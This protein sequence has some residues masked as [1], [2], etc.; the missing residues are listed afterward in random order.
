MCAGPR[1][2]LQGRQVGSISD[3]GAFSFCQDKILTGGEGGMLVTNDTDAWAKAW[4]YKDHGK[5]YDAIYRQPTPGPG[6][7]NWVH[8]S[9]GTN[10]RITE[11]QAAIGRVQLRKLGDWLKA[12]RRNAA[13]LT[14]TL[15]RVPGLRVTVP[16]PDVGHAYYKYYVFVRP[17]A[18]RAEWT[19][20]RIVAA[21]S[22][23]G[24]P[25]A[26]G[27]CSEIYLEKAFPGP[28]RPVE[29]LRVARELGETS[30]MF[31]VHPTLDETDMRDTAQAAA[32]V[33]HAAVR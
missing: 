25:C 10:W 33:M 11:M 1:R 12:R 27:S 32:K 31:M 2:D 4:S 22:R 16:P 18:L 28:M 26:V 24:V 19:R 20:D 13:V 5:S 14:D 8:E 3:M 6:L 7:F 9:F 15:S 17:E 30:L 23:E 21:V 29:R